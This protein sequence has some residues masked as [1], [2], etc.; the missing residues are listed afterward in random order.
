[1]TNIHNV[2]NVILLW[3]LSFK[4]ISAA[5]W[6]RWIATRNGLEYTGNGSD[7][8]ERLIRTHRFCTVY[9]SATGFVGLILFSVY[10]L[11]NMG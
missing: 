5:L 6:I 9:G 11:M 3:A 7:E 8:K 4:A 2:Q 1:M 10:I